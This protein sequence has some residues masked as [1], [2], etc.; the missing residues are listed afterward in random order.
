MLP[1]TGFD[2]TKRLSMTLNFWSSVSDSSVLGLQVRI[3]TPGLCGA[4]DGTRA[5]YTLGQHF[6]N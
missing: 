1:Q 6:T 4:G 5:V 2:Y 3:A